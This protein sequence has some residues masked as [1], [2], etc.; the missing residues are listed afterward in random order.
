M[1]LFIYKNDKKQEGSKQ[2]DFKVFALINEKFV[3][4]GGAWWNKDKKGTFYQSVVVEMQDKA[5]EPVIQTAEPD[6]EQPPF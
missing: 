4:V 5:T 3:D 6:L 1:K 2:P